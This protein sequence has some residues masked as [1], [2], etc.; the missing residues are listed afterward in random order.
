VSAFL[1][2]ALGADMEAGTLVEQLIS[3]G[4]P[5]SRGDIIAVVETQK[6]AIEIEVFE[7]GQLERWMVG[8]GQKVPVG[9]PLAMIRTTGDPEAPQPQ[10]PV[11]TPPQ[12]EEPQPAVPEPEPPGPELP[13]PDLPMPD[14]PYPELRMG[15]ASCRPARHRPAANSAPQRRNGAPCR[16]AG[17]GRRLQ[18]AGHAAG[19]RCRHGTL[20]TRDS[21]LLPLASDGPDAA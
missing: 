21:A 4:T 18:G 8:I 11:P 7:D 1:M 9:T 15:A 16:C 17:P 5:V 20:E 6:G 10:D 19:H 12:P 2:P 13:P 14:Q 3:P